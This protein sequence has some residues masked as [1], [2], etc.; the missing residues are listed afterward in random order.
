M[1]TPAPLSAPASDLSQDPVV[2]AWQHALAAEHAAIFGY[3]VLGPRLV[4]A[5]DVAQARA[6]QSAH[7][8]IRDQTIEQLIA[9]S[10]T[11]TAPQV[12]YPLPFPVLDAAAA[13]RYAVALEEA[14]GSAWRYV[15]A[16][17]AGPARDGAA[18]ASATATDSTAQT[19]TLS[20]DALRAL[21]A[22]A[23]TNLTAGAIRAMRWRLLV[24]PSRPTVPFPGI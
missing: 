13:R 7:E 22:T 3:E 15:I 6:A 10:V 8:Q 14:T 21:R 2:V 17:A 18:Q 19:S 4:A 5:P 9:L 1:T 12:D 16:T 11:P 23:Q 20:A 24:L